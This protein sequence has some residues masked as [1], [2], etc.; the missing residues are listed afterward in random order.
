M[1][2]AFDYFVILAEM[3]T[4]SNFLEANLNAFQ[5]VECH[6]E[7]FNPHFIG[8][9]NKTEVL[10]V[11]LA[12]RE[13]D[14]ARLIDVIRKR[15]NGLGGFRFFNDHDPRALDICMNDPRC[16]KIILTRNPLDS[17]VSLKIA[18]ATGQWKLTNVKRRKDSK[19]KFES[20][21]FERHVS[22]LQDFQVMLLNRL[23]ISGQT[24]F[25]IA[26]EDLK[27][28]DIINGLA[29][30]LGV[31]EQLDKLDASLKK[32]NPK[33]LSDKVSNFKE[34]Q[35]TVAGLDSFN[36]N[37]TPNFEPR[38]GAAVPGFVAGAQVPLLYMP[39]RSG[40][41]AQICAWLAALDDVPEDKL[42]TQLNQKA[43]RQWK[44]RNQGH[45]S[46]TVLRHPVARAHAAFC[47]KI[48]SQG[49]GS[50]PEIRKTLRNFHKLPIPSG[51]SDEGYDRQAHRQGFVAFLDFLRANLAGQTGIRID[52]HWATQ[53]SVLQGM[54]NFSLPDVV[55]RESE[56][57]VQLGALAHQVGY[58]GA[59]APMP[60]GPDL[61]FDL[62]DI[63]DDEVEALAS[64]V[65][66]RDYL[67]FG[68]DRWA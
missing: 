55:I 40:P 58:S 54:A 47:S 51:S 59:F 5:G 3:R 18:Q 11:T 8:Y 28:L 56:A 23:Q 66:R 61:P 43:L 62:A 14:P 44:R 64:E 33:A 25:Y 53:A 57:K 24:A 35:D 29:R 12:M 6:G 31:D 46:F 32:Q 39:V 60:A 41:E 63:Y 17:Y 45:R 50:Y 49:E 22:Q 21:E 30:F 34:M 4:G 9:P 16:A 48:L 42:L 67:M 26:Y 65:Y 68:F 20:E 2:G 15:S 19:V 10:E 13:T 1:S 38:R 36:L 27:N 52:P 7:A 37:R